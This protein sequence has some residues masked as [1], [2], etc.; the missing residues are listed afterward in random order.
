MWRKSHFD[1][2]LYV[3]KLTLLVCKPSV[4]Q[5]HTGPPLT[6]SSLLRSC[7]TSVPL[8]RSSEFGH[9][10]GHVRRDPKIPTHFD[11]HSETTPEP[12]WRQGPLLEHTGERTQDRLF[13]ILLPQ[14]TEPRTDP[15]TPWLAFVSVLPALACRGGVEGGG[16]NPSCALLSLTGL[17][18]A[19]VECPR[20]SYPLGTGQVW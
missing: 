9:E 13:V 18:T 6:M 8:G 16:A 10:S 7:G 4:P 12:P 17:L 19:S 3:F 1:R 5:T 11:K 20:R 2:V 15:L 14:E